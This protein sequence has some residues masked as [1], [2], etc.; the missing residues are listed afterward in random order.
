[1]EESTEAFLK[2]HLEESS[3]E[4]RKLLKRIS[5]KKFLESTQA[6]FKILRKNP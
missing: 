3:D 1:M 4:F 5:K 2:K 6:L